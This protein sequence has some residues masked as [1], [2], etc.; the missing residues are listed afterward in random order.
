MFEG[1]RKSLEAFGFVF[2]L[3]EVFRFVGGLWRS[4]EVLRIGTNTDTGV[5]IDV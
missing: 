2:N 3:L 1:F 5:G 4:L